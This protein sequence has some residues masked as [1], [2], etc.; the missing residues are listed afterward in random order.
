M[1]RIPRFD[2]STFW[3]GCLGR[4]SILAPVAIPANCHVVHPLR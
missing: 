3:N 4:G 1:I 2:V